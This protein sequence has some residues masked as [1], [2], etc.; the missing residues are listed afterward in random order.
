L[1]PTIVGGQPR[2]TPLIFDFDQNLP[3]ARRH[4]DALQAD[5]AE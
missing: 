4:K 2:R 1:N 5:D 3:P